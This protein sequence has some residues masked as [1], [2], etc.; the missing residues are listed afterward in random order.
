MFNGFS[1]FLG[2]RVI[3]TMA[4]FPHRRMPEPRA[5]AAAAVATVCIERISHT[6]IDTNK[7]ERE[8]ECRQRSVEIFLIHATA[9]A[10]HHTRKSE[11]FTSS[12]SYERCSYNSAAIYSFHYK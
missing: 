5:A 4:S 6:K 12:T 7:L 1:T 9:V 10:A 8:R 3:V 2:A 11:W